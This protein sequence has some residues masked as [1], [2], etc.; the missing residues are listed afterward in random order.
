MFKGLFKAGAP[1]SELP[2][3]RGGLEDLVGLEGQGDEIPL[4]AIHAQFDSMGQNRP[5]DSAR[6]AT[7]V[8]VIRSSSHG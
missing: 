8:K 2:V 3:P 1:K 6:T 5:V 7:L 4:A